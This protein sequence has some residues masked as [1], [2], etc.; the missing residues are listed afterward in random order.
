MDMF[1]AKSKIKLTTSFGI[2]DLIK[3]KG[4][5][6]KPDIQILRKSDLEKC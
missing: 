1:Y 2:I 5:L 6:I 4:L 3:N